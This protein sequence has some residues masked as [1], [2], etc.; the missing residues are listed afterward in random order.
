MSA[1]LQNILHWILVSVLTITAVTPAVD[2]MLST[3]HLSGPQL[4]S[5]VVGILTAAAV[6]FVYYADNT[7]GVTPPGGQAN[8]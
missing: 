7:T 8:P 6:K 1:K 2:Q 4:I 3:G 5:G